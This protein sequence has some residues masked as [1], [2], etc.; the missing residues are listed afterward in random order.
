VFINITLKL[1]SRK[2]T[3]TV[4]D[5]T[6]IPGELLRLSDIVYAVGSSYFAR[7]V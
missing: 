5:P 1:E 4:I 2:M 3:V 6:T 7:F